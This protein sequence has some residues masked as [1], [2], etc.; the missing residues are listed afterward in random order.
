MLASQGSTPS[1]EMEPMAA[2]QTFYQAV[3]IVPITA[4]FDLRAHGRAISTPRRAL[5]RGRPAYISF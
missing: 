4:D 5:R 2:R 3:V 1:S